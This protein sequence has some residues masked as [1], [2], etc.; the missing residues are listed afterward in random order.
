[1]NLDKQTPLVRAVERGAKKTADARSI[2]SS[3]LGLAAVFE[4]VE[5]DPA[6]RQDPAGAY[7]VGKLGNR[8]GGVKKTWE[9]ACSVRT[10]RADVGA[11][12]QALERLA[13][14]RWTRSICTFTTSGTRRALAGSKPGCRSTV[15]EILGLANISETGTYLNASGMALQDSMKCFDASP[16][17]PGANESP[18]E[19]PSSGHEKTEPLSKDLLH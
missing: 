6:G 9:P 11:E 17:K 15:K 7:T 5:T 19:H 3:L 4:M 12:W 8:V 1:V 2:R 16:G 18:I 10:A 14:P 13:A